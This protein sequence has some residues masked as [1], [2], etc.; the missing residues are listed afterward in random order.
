MVGIVAIGSL[1]PYSA[2]TYF[3]ATKSACPPDAT[4]AWLPL[5]HPASGRHA[6][7]ISAPDIFIGRF[8]ATM[9]F[10]GFAGLAGSKT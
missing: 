2:D 8:F 10:G 3:D 1:S 5:P 4:N 7:E 6:N 9:G